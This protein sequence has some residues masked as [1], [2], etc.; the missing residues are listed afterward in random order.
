MAML[1]IT[2][3]QKSF[4]VATAEEKNAVS[5]RARALEKLLIAWEKAEND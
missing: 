2:N 5:H 3:L 4:G 1:R